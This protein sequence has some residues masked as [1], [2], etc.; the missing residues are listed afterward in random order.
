MDPTFYF[1]G[2]RCELRRSCLCLNFE[3]QCLVLFYHLRRLWL[4]CEGVMEME[5]VV[6]VQNF[7]DLLR[8]GFCFSFV[9]MLLALVME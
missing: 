4:I 2:L 9:W 3:Y 5:L 1:Q 8:I 6:K 7:G